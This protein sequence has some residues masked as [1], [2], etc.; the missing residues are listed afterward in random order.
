M[1]NQN[2]GT[3][4]NWVPE[5]IT[6]ILF[7]AVGL[8]VFK[9]PASSYVALSIFFAITFLLT[10][11]MKTSFAF[12][13]RKYVA[14]WGWS[15]AG[16]IIDILIGV[17]LVST[18]SLSITVLPLFIGFALLFRSAQAIGLSVELSR[19]RIPDW[20][21]LLFFG[22]LGLVL[23]FIMLWNPVFAG[24][25]IVVYT[26]MAFISI[27][28]FQIFLSFRLKKLSKELK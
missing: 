13:S 16:G 18:P 6:G 27:G 12:S 4:R 15:F 3:G 20:G 28:I 21:W 11:I 26:V 9:T 7:V 22:I 25:S 23:A 2:S 1:V 19:L 8:W 17:L 5:L 14:G 10:G 24:L